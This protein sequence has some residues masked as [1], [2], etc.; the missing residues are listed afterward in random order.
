MS[1]ATRSTCCTLL[2]V[3][4]GLAC[5]AH[6]S[7]TPEHFP[8]PPAFEHKGPLVELFPHAGPGYRCVLLEMKTGSLLV[9]MPDGQQRQYLLTNL[10]G[11][12]FLEAPPPDGTHT[13]RP[14]R[15]PTFS[16]ADMARLKLLKQK[17]RKNGDLTAAESEDLRKLRDR[18]PPFL[19]MGRLRE[20]IKDLEETIS[21]EKDKGRLDSFVEQ[22]KSTIKTSDKEDAVRE[23]LLALALV[24]RRRGYSQ[25]EIHDQLFK[26]IATLP[27]ETHRDDLLEK[28]PGLL[29]VLRQPPDGGMPRREPPPPP[30]PGPHTP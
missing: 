26:D 19:R 12:K 30:P 23:S 8:P 16:I 7:D 20:I 4:A 1:M 21:A 22:Q 29:D 15:E 9:Q 27:N 14:D 17:E 10:R 3:L 13:D 5:P 24:Y 28:L 6:S 11:M 25:R 2:L 18:I